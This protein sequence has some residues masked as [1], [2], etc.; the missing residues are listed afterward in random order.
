MTKRV[1]AGQGAR[2]RPGDR[3]SRRADLGARSDFGR[4]LRRPH[5]HAAEDA[6]AHRLHGHPRSRQ[7]LRHL[8][9]GRG[10]RPRQGRRR[11]VRLT[12][13]CF[14]TI[15]GSNPTFTAREAWFAPGRS[16]R[17]ALSAPWTVRPRTRGAD[18]METRANFVLIGAFTLAA[19]VAAFLFVMWIVGYGTSGVHRHYQIV[20][21]G[22]VSGLSNGA[23]VLF[24]GLKVGEVTNLEL[25]RRQS[26]PGRRRHR[27]DQR[28]RADQREHQGA[29]RDAGPDGLG[30]G[31]ADRRGEGRGGADRRGRPS[32][33]HS[34]AADGDARGPAD[35]GRLRARSRQQAAGRQRPAHPPDDRERAVLLDGARQQRR[36]RRR[37]AE[38]PRRSRQ[39]DRAAG[40]APAGP[41]RRRRQGRQGDRAGQG[42]RNRRQRRKP[43]GESRRGAGPGRQADRRKRR[44]DP[45]D[46]VERQR[47]LQDPRPTIAPTSTRR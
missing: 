29:A 45:D 23:L 39:D 3:L 40:D 2:A 33:R 36:W 22:S 16:G 46:N 1:V 28:E 11:L 38:G 21:N 41:L 26:E 4:R 5:R 35:E 19:V 6:R 42:A 13:F 44:G 7:P 43:V 30:H 31:R 9:P 47:L 14:P 15:L 27:R 8:R 10:A 37:G 34:L 32:A 18:G 17:G 20:F 24:N 25:R 12:N